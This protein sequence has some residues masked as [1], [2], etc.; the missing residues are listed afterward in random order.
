MSVHA[1]ILSHGVQHTRQS[2]A[3]GKEVEELL[4][5]VDVRQDAVT[6]VLQ[7]LYRQDGGSVL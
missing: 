3:F 4:G 1:C 2:V 5:G 6:I 7:S